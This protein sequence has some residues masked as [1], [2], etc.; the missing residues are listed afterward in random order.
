MRRWATV[1]ALVFPLVVGIFHGNE[2]PLIKMVFAAENCAP[3][4]AAFV[5]VVDPAHYIDRQAHFRAECCGLVTVVRKVAFYG[6]PS[7]DIAF[8][9]KLVAQLPMIGG[10][11]GSMSPPMKT[12]A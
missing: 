4:D 12:I 8:G 2:P 5:G 3:W 6:C 1:A 7:V 11:M 10:R 9:K